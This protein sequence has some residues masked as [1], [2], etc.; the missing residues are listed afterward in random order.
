MKI[1]ESSFSSLKLIKNFIGANKKV[2]LINTMNRENYLK[3]S[4]L[5]YL[6]NNDDMWNLNFKDEEYISWLAKYIKEKDFDY[7]FFKTNDKQENIVKYKEFERKHNVECIVTINMQKNEDEEFTQDEKKQ[8]IDLLNELQ[9]SKIIL[10]KVSKFTEEYYRQYVDSDENLS[11]NMIRK[12]LSRNIFLSKEVLPNKNNKKL[13]LYE[14]LEILV[15]KDKIIW[16]KKRDKIKNNIDKIKM[17]KLNQI[18]EIKNEE[19]NYD[20]T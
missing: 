16:L 18:L 1:F 20:W 8:I 15:N 7:I 11:Y 2:L 9:I 17:Q 10:Y 4:H 12:I 3:C 6:K 5:L 19:V 13:Y 14:D